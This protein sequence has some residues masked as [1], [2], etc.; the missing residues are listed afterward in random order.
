MQRRSFIKTTGFS[1]SALAF[2]GHNAIAGWL[3]DPSFQ[4]KMLSKEAGIFTEK[5]G[6]ILFLL[7]KEG[8][9]VVD[10]QFPDTAA[11]LVDELKKRSDR[12][13]HLLINT[14]HHRDHSSGNIA[15]KDISKHVLAHA[16][17]L[18]HQ[19]AM[20][21]KQKTEAQ[22]LYPD[23]TFTE[24]W[25]EKLGKE[26]ICLYHFGAGHTNGDSLI[27]FE[28]QGVVHLGDLLFN[29]RHPYVDMSSGA[30]INSW[31]QVLE[32]AS[33]HFPAKTTFVCGHAAAGYDVVVKK[34][35][36]LLFRD[37]LG[38]VLR[39]TESAIKEGKTKEELILAKEIPGSP[40]WT[41]DGIDRPL[42][43]AYEEL[44]KK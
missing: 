14:H 23:L 24:S 39:F 33:T 43:A 28:K 27:H 26:N 30:N 15:F 3:N 7:N 41:G 11:H 21:I 13:F 19:Q 8:I 9:V 44:T 36:L 31:M 4:I 10:A 37:Y 18:K 16:N 32:K 20:A 35:D 2:L 22:Q 42:S 5:G 29:R 40:Q 12:P 34:E 38:N 17:S 1:L 6:T 25:C